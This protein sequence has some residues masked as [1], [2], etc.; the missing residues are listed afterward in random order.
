MTTCRTCN[1]TRRDRYSRPCSCTSDDLPADAFLAL[2]AA[3]GMLLG[4]DDFRVLMGNPR[5]KQM[6]HTS[7]LHGSGVV[8]G[9]PVSDDGVNVQVGPG[10]AID[11]LGRELRIETGQCVALDAAWVAAWLA[12]ER[13]GDQGGDV[14][15]VTDLAVLVAAEPPEPYD[16]DGDGGGDEDSYGDK[17]SY[18]DEGAY[19]EDD[20]D[21]ED[22]DQGLSTAWLVAEF[23]SCL[24][25]PVPVLADPCDVSR[26]HDDWSRVLETARLVITDQP[27]VHRAPYRRLRVLLGLERPRRGDELVLRALRR[28]A[29]APPYRVAGVLLRQ[30]HRLAALDV[31]DLAPEPSGVP[32]CP[33]Q[34]PVTEQHSGVVLARLRFRLP[35]D[36]CSGVTDLTVSS[37]VRTALLPTATIQDL[38]C[39]LAP[40]LIAQQGPRDAH[41][42]RL[43]PESVCWYRDAAVSFRL[44]RPVLW[45][46][47]E[48][49]LEISSLSPDGRGWRR[50]DHI[51]S[52]R[53]TEDGR[54]LVRLD[55]PPAYP[56]VRLLLRGTGST[57]LVGENPLVPFAGVVGGPAGTRHDGHDAA[58][59]VRLPHR[60][61]EVS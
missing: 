11:G 19:D 58:V 20:E 27:P 33:A 18:G 60:Y 44:T 34:L 5:G 54:I 17:E 46:S 26:S 31:Q 14:E 36:G 47:W 41:G 2:R 4:E 42:P 39:G 53:V 29:A 1:D 9:L 15:A 12:S 23:D 51:D 61:W 40:G 57:V 24:T 25:E 10:L 22:D 21:D 52:V 13:L 32:D 16:D 59:N 45:G 30:F 3:F 35:A 55:G 8:W 38:L 56:L 50:H 6:L 48:H 49:G 43:I 7:W 37:D 28:I